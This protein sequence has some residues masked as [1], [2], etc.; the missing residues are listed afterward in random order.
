MKERLKMKNNKGVTLI[1]LI[2]TLIVMLILIS[3]TMVTVKS[4]NS[5]VKKANINNKIY[6]LREV[7]QAVLEAY[8]KY[9]QTN[10][11]NYLAGT[12]LES[13]DLLNE[14]EKGINGVEFKEKENFN[15]YYKLDSKNALLGIGIKNSSDYY[16]VNYTTGEVLNYTTKKLSDGTILYLNS[17]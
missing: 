6:E 14:Y 10:N 15:N 11:E 7:H 13:A 3:I 5:A 9:K 8:I 12:K 2:T 17:D 16:I 1:A 4:S